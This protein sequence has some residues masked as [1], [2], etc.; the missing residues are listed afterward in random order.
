VVEF[1]KRLR[2]IIGRHSPSRRGVHYEG[3]L[4]VGPCRYC[5]AELE[6][7]DNDRWVARPQA[8]GQKRGG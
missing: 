5:G 4:K 3:H 6:K 2:C 7:R 1:L 8:K